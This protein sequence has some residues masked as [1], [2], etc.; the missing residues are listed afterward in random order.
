LIYIPSTPFHGVRFLEP[1]QLKFRRLLETHDLGR[2]V[3]ERVNGLL[4]ERG[5]KVSGGTM[6]DATII[7][8]PS[9]TKNATQSR[10]PEMHQTRKGKQ[11]Y[12][13]MKL[14]IGAD[15]QTGLLHSATTTAAHVHDSK[16]LPDLLHGA[17]TRL[18]GDSAYRGQKT[19]LQSIAP[20]ARDFTNERAYS[21]R[22]LTDAQK[23]K[24]LVK[25]DAM[26]LV[27]FTESWSKQCNRYRRECSRTSTGRRRS[28]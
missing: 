14:H 6:V 9:S 3:F 28:N 15:T 20:K 7:H 26:D 17:E 2:A 11:W 27:F 5:M 18:Y 25:T 8:A 23:W 10:D 21:A 4:A 13:G 16:A 1:L 19:I 12:F 22:P 24:G